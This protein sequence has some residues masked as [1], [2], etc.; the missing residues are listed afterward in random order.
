MGI[1]SS[2]LLVLFIFAV[3]GAGVWIGMSLMASGLFALLAF[4]DRNVFNLLGSV[5][6]SSS[7]SWT[8]TALPLFLWMGEILFR[9]KVSARLFNGLSPWVSLIPGRLLHTNVIGCTIFAAISGSSAATCATVGKVTLPEF[10][11]RA[12]PESIVLGSLAGAGTLGLLIPPSIVMIV[13]GV[14]ADVS[15]GKL[16]IA[17]VLPGLLLAFLFSCY[18]AFWSLTHPGALPREETRWTL[19]E[20]MKASAGIL[21]VALLIILVLGSIYSG[22][23]TPTESAVLGVIGSLAISLFEGSLTRRTFV[24]GMMAAVRV[25]A[26]IGLILMGAAFLTLAMGYTGIPAQIA[27]FVTDLGLSSVGLIFAL[28]IVYVILGCFL[29]GVSLILLTISV[30][31]P[32]LNA[33]GIDLLWFGIFIIIV[34]EAA[35]ITPPIGFNLFVIQ[36]LTGRDILTIARYT[37]P[38][39]L[40][41]MLLVVLITAFPQ[42]VMYLPT[43]VR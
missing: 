17:G 31:L 14:A 6:W 21:P 16:F 29:D 8:L 36:S 13:Y 28:T 39:F 10:R 40:I 20:R 33:V 38:Q 35:Q 25:S 18:I 3:L 24:E 43:A 37:I 11:K 15:I 9:S 41:L 7:T 23:A 34:V 5:L 30:L 1:G 4:T 32:A 2:L 27:R 42:I 26:M 19:L 22:V 12:Y